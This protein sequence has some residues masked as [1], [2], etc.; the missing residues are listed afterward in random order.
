MPR[1]MDNRELI[2]TMVRLTKKQRNRLVVISQKD[3]RSISSLIRL[4]IDKYLGGCL[5]E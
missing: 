1:K 5:N 2:P 4:A 3:D